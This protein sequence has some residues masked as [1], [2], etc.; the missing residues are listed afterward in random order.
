MQ[1]SDLNVSGALRPLGCLIP[2]F[3]IRRMRVGFRVRLSPTTLAD[4]ATAGPESDFETHLARLPITQP[5]AHP[6]GGG[7]VT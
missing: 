5:A 3:W 1:L 6:A 2:D 4:P 7:V